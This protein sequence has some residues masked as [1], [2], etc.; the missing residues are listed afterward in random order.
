[1]FPDSGVPV[2][3]REECV[4][5]SVLTGPAVASFG[6]SL[7]AAAR[8]VVRGA[9]EDSLALVPYLRLV[10]LPGPHLVGDD[11]RPAVRQVDRVAPLDGLRVSYL[12]GLQSCDNETIRGLSGEE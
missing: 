1:M 6:L 8:L 3:F 5:N 11:L 4:I 12:G 9:R 10:S 2:D 7:E